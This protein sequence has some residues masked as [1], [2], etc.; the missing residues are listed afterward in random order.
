[1]LTRQRSLNPRLFALVLSV[2]AGL[3]VLLGAMLSAAQ[4]TPLGSLKEFRVPTDDSQP[5]HITVGSE[6]NLQFTER[7]E[8]FT[9][10]PDSEMGGTFHNHIGRITPAGEIEEFRVEGCQCFLNDIVQGPGDVLYY[11]TNN[12]RAWGA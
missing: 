3:A 2:V 7:N 9:P 12:L 5:R 6:G 11:T 4:A 1:M 8:F 10:D